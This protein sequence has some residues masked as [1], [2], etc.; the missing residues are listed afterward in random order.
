MT[1]SEFMGEFV[2]MLQT[3]EDLQLTTPL[4]NLEEWDS[5]AFMVLITFFDKNFDLRLT[6]EDLAACATPED[7]IALSQ[8]AIS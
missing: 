4:E 2:E 1:K 8:G 6:F 7:V 5:L 3:E